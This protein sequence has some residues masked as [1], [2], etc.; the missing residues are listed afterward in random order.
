M[1]DSPAAAPARPLAGLR[2]LDCSHIL[3][4]PYATFML[5]L[6]GADIVKIERPPVGDGLRDTATRPELGGITANIQSVNAGKRSIALDL[7]TSGGRAVLERL[8]PTADVF[9][10]NFRPGKMASL[11]F[12]PDR[13]HALNPRIV[14][15]SISAWGQTGPLAA[16]GGYDH[17]M[18]AATGMMWAQ[19]DDPEAPPVKVGFP[20]IDMATGL[21][22]AI[23]LL[24]AILRR[25]GGEEGPIAVDISMADASLCLM[26]GIAHGWLIEGRAP[27][28]V[29]NVGFTASPGAGVFRCAEGW[30]S[31]AASTRAQFDAL[32]AALGHPEWST[33]PDWLT[34]RPESP[35]A[36]LRGLG[37]P[38][39]KAALD[40]AFLARGAEAWETLLNAADVPASAVRSIAEFLEGPYRQT[41]GSSFRVPD[42][43][44]PDGALHEVLGAGFRWTGGAPAATAPAPRLGEH[45]DAVLAEAGF[46][47]AAI[48]DLRRQGAIR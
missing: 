38:R 7:G 26:A 6:M 13:V 35:G 42:P 11:G 40:E 2:V 33:A 45:T 36:I 39:L 24:G 12:G 21:V 4:G 5:G 1:H 3:A 20:A 25:R 41:G 48:A 30:L 37:T 19:G 27:P 10:E 46:D 14:Y 32:C 8:I 16:R 44:S 18:Q 34:R 23:G 31:V 15:A 17:V 47:A 9:L 22:G 29:G 43:N 28:R